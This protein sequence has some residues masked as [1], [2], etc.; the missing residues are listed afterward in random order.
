MNTGGSSCAQRGAR[1][2]A[3]PA[4]P[5]ATRAA[6]AR[7]R[8]GGGRDPASPTLGGSARGLPRAGVPRAGLPLGAEG[9]EEEGNEGAPIRRRQC[10][11]SASSPHPEQRTTSAATPSTPS[12][13]HV[14]RLF[15][16]DGRGSGSHVGWSFFYACAGRS[17]GGWK[18]VVGASVCARAVQPAPAAQEAASQA[19]TLVERRGGG[20]GGGDS[21]RVRTVKKRSQGPQRANRG[22][23]CVGG[24][25]RVKQTEGGG[26]A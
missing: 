2:L 15:Q 14:E 20:K 5:R 13:T 26:G 12:T 17:F 16:G 19:K 21:A 23:V 3:P 6:R 7:A 18:D 22:C 1:T 25:G 11:R 8:R 24:G 10:S 9:W 4:L